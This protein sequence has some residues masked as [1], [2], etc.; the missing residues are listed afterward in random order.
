MPILPS[1]SANRWH[2]PAVENIETATAAVSSA[3][4]AGSRVNG[5]GIWW[6]WGFL[7]NE[8]GGYDASGDRAAWQSSTVALPFSP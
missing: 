6:G 7:S 5:A 8:E 2:I 4:G 3:L 1:Y